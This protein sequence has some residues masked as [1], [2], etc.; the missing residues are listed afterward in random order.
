MERFSLILLS[1][2]VDGEIFRLAGAGITSVTVRQLIVRGRVTTRSVLTVAL[3]D[4]TFDTLGPHRR[5][6]IRSATKCGSVSPQLDVQG[7]GSRD[8]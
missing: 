1:E 2:L 6:R 3:G 8:G 4:R 5:R 7:G